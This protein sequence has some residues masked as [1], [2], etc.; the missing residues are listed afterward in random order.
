M[1]ID[2]HK[3]QAQGNDFVIFDGITHPLP[4]LSAEIVQRVA[5][6]RQG[7]GCDQL[8]ALTSDDDA[9]V[10][11][12]I[13]NLDGSQAAN[14]GNGLRCVAALLMERTGHDQVTLALTDRQVTATRGEFGIKVTLGAAEITESVEQHCDVSIGNPHRVFFEM[15]E[16]LPDDRNIEIVTGQ[17]GDHLYID[18]IELGV[19]RTPACGTGACASVAA[20]WHRE[21]HHRPQI[22]HMPGGDVR[23]SGTLHQMLLE[24]S[25]NY[26][27]Q[28]SYQAEEILT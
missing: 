28:G 23:V 17:I 8:L 24:G 11:V 20:L 19:G 21:Q 3:M 13:F 27:F 26:V 16:I 4:T 9:D 2:F 25:V 22:V 12:Q 5:D 10:R 15:Q 1:K 7:I 18:I 14:C 6:R